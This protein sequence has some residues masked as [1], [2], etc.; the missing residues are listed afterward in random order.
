MGLHSR[1][2]GAMPRHR[3][4]GL[5]PKQKRFVDEYLTDL[6][7]TQAAI[8][9][10]YKVTT[11][12]E[13]AARL[14]AKSRVQDAVAV[15]QAKRAGRLEVTQDRVIAELAK[16]AFADTRD[17]YH[18]DGRPKAPN[19]LDA[20]TA[21]A[22]SS[23]ETVTRIG[24]DGKQEISY[25]IRLHPKTSALDLLAQHLGITG[26]HAES[27]LNLVA[28]LDQRTIQ[29]W[30]NEKIEEALRIIRA[31]KALVAGTADGGTRH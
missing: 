2:N 30:P 31:A 18:Q 17:L 8:R 25:R 28:F 4:P 11:A 22:V 26:R 19:E 14:L 27:H 20:H 10:G 16:L 15:G 3:I 9:A 13:Q 23:I 21:A 7:A 6:N 12:P 24:K 5:T 1:D 29:S